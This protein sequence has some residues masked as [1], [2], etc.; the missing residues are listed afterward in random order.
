METSVQEK[1]I[2]DANKPDRD[3][4]EKTNDHLRAGGLKTTPD[5]L[6]PTHKSTLDKIVDNL[7]EGIG[8]KAGTAINVVSIPI[9]EGIGQ[10]TERI[11]LAEGSGWRQKLAGRIRG[12]IPFLRRK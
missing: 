1:V 5:E 4:L 6:D 3:L 11:Q 10:G 9:Q 7:M 2:Q 12:K 8:D